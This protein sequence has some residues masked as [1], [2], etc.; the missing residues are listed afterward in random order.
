Y[1]K[2]QTLTT[3]SYCSYPFYCTPHPHFH[4][5]FSLTS[6]MAPSTACST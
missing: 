2:K 3:S 5:S 4:Q 6:S 1:K